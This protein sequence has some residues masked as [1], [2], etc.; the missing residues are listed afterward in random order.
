MLHPSKCLRVIPLTESLLD[1]II[2]WID[3]IILQA[4][5]KIGIVK[6]VLFEGSKLWATG[7]NNL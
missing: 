1:F 7:C 6:I 3:I 5:L 2:S 4:N